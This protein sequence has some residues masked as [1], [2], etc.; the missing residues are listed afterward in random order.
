MSH[1]EYLN[2]V[3]S[4]PL[5]MN[6]FSETGQTPKIKMPKQPLSAQPK[7]FCVGPMN[8]F[9]EYQEVTIF[10]FPFSNCYMKIVREFFFC[11]WSFLPGLYF[12]PTDITFNQNVTNCI[13][14]SGSNVETNIQII[15][16]PKMFLPIIKDFKKV[17][18][19][20]S[21]IS[22]LI[23]FKALLIPLGFGLSLG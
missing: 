2:A 10:F 21:Y 23:L 4:P 12:S 19:C 8:R 9:P 18:N 17:K 3:T 20:I 5:L 16:K 15:F 13:S 14:P 6:G 22:F 7:G 1:R 11:H